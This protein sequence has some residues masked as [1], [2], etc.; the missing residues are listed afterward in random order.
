MNA[1]MKAN[2]DN[3]VETLPEVKIKYSNFLLV[4]NQIYNRLMR[5]KLVQ[6]E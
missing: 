2:I 3:F 1:A 4:I 5:L 6:E